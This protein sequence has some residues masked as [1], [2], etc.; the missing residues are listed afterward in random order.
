MKYLELKEKKFVV[1]IK[2][3][4]WK[5]LTLVCGSQGTDLRGTALL[6]EGGQDYKNQAEVTIYGVNPRWLKNYSSLALHKGKTISQPETITITVGNH[7]LFSGDSFLTYADY[8]NFPNVALKISAAFGFSAALV[9]RDPTYIRA[10]EKLRFQDVADALV[11]DLNKDLGLTLQKKQISGKYT[12]DTQNT[13]LP[14]MTLTGTTVEKLQT[15]ADSMGMR[16]LI[17]H[18][19]AY[20]W[21]PGKAYPD[22]FLRAKPVISRDT[23]LIGYPSFY[24]EGINFSVSD[25]GTYKVGDLIRLKSGV[26]YADGSY[27]LIHQRIELSTL[28]GGKWEMQC[29]AT[30]DF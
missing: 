15:L 18:T 17:D 5:S 28:P 26:P 1:S 19:G 8:S 23:C 12:R 10:E 24:N 11:G 14:D 16:R 3:P 25:I 21:M 9:Q 13:V 2:R 30:Y 29:N 22:E 27:F 20:F 4:G 7:I 6:E